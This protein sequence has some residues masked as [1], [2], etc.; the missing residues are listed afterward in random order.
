[1][2]RF[3]RRAR[4]ELAETRAAARK[5]IVARELMAK[6]DAVLAKP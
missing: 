4:F 3:H 6:I 2:R 1:V 5:T